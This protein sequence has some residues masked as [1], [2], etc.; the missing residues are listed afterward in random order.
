MN[1]QRK[2]LETFFIEKLH[3]IIKH[4]FKSALYG[5][6]CSCFFIL[7]VFFLTYM[8]VFGKI[9]NRAELRNLKNP[10]TSTLYSSQKTVLATYFLQN[11]SNIDS[12]EL[13]NY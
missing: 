9:P 8:G 1:L 11:R 2:K 12:T 13:N 10:I 7:F 4:P 3:F 5:F 6:L